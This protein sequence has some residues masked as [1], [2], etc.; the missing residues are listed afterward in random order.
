MK[1]IILFFIL[2]AAIFAKPIDP[3]I[4]EKLK[5]MSKELGY[6]KVYLDDDVQQFEFNEKEFP[7]IMNC[8]T[9]FKEKQDEFSRKKITKKL[10]N[11]DEKNNFYREIFF[12]KDK[13]KIEGTFE[14]ANE[15]DDNVEH[16]EVENGKVTM[17]PEIYSK[18]GIVI[19]DNIKYDNTEN[20]SVTLNQMTYYCVFASGFLEK[21]FVKKIGK[22]Y[23]KEGNYEYIY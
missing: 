20:N 22:V 19:L 12:A 16:I 5:S 9:F 14:I 15:A 13:A 3:A 2:S 4:Y 10:Y 1:K 18:H 6:S 7:V 17:Y 11:E 23:D 8:K 21:S